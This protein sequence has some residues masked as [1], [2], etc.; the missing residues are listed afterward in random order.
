[1]QALVQIKAVVAPNAYD[2][3]QPLQRQLAHAQEDQ[4]TPEIGDH[5][6]R[7]EPLVRLC[8]RLADRN[9]LHV[10]AKQIGKE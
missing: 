9:A 3:S 1:M 5:V 10:R 7:A 4:A 6:A 8:D 2:A